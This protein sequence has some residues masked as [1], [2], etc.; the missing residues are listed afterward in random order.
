MNGS[1]L[2]VSILLQACLCVL[3]RVIILCHCLCYRSE[4]V[5]MCVCVCVCVCV[6]TV[7]EGSSLA[8]NYLGKLCLKPSV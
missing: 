1:V 2:D 6:F 8:N 4:C 5:C 3:L 7:V